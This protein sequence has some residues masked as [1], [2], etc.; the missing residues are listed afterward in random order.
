VTYYGAAVLYECDTNYK[1]DG[2]SRRICLE[3]GTWSHEVPTCK[4]I[5]CE[6]PNISENVIVDSGVQLVGTVAKFT[7]SRG[8]YLVGNNTRSCMATGFWSGKS[9]I[10]RGEILYWRKISNLNF[11]SVLTKTSR[12]SAKALAS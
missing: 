8:R 7:C 3:N 1:L 10:C 9:P 4:E 2:V 5:S 11:N 6:I 12:S